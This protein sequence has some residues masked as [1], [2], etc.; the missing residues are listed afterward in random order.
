MGLLLIS[1]VSWSL[2]GCALWLAV[3]N[4]LPVN[5]EEKW[6]AIANILS[7]AVAIAAT[8]YLFIFVLV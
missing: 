3:G 1:L 4:Q 2:L 5:D 8:L 7:Y 6:P